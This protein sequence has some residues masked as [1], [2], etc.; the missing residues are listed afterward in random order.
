MNSPAFPYSTLIDITHP[1][2]EQTTLFSGD[3]PFTREHLMRLENGDPANMLAVSFCLHSGTHLDAPYHILNDGKRLHEIEPRRF[4]G[5]ALVLPCSN[6][7]VTVADLEGK[8]IE[9]GMS[10]LLKTNQ[11]D[12]SF[13]FLST[14]AAEY[15][16]SLGVNIVGTDA[17]SPEPYDDMTLPVH[18][19]LLSREVLILENCNLSAVEAG[20]YTLIVAPL[21]ITDGDGSPVRAFLLR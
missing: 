5:P 1:L 6:R 18:H 3:P 4:V 16:V 21:F 9:A 17:L 19:I 10:V 8:G 12:G 20:F 14:E 11:G 13:A 7:T 15:V 2:D